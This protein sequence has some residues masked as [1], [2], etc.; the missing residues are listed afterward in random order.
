MQA[1]IPISVCWSFVVTSF[2]KC[3][4]RIFDIRDAMFALGELYH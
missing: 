3:S 2:D 1:L 4:L